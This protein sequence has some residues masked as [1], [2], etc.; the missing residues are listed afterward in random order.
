MI[1]R[2]FVSKEQIPIVT[3]SDAHHIKNVLRMKAGEEIE[4]LDGTGKV[5]SSKI[6]KVEKDKIICKVVSTRFEEPKSPLKVT[7][8]QCVPKAKKMDLIIQKC[9]E[10]GADKFIPALSERAIARKEKMN[11]WRAIAKE[12]AEQSGRTSIP[13]IL[14]LS[15]FEEVLNLRDQ[16]ESALIPWE[17]ERET[18]LKHIL[19]TYP[20]KNLLI[21]IGPEGGFSRKE[22]EL[23]KS[24]GFIPVSLGPRILRT[25]TVG[26]AMLSMINYEYS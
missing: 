15:K 22:I 6:S 14:P 26:I 16:Y 2:F 19:T 4:L 23:A 12:A 17:L 24:S 8:A 10:L 1:S 20:P 7:L 21:L 3:G 13:E 18:S 25:E 11:H 5:Y 9:T